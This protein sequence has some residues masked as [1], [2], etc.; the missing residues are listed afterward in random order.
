MSSLV[1]IE[2][3]HLK[4]CPY[5]FRFYTINGDF[6]K[7][8]HFSGNMIYTYGNWWFDSEQT[9]LVNPE[10]YTKAVVETIKDMMPHIY[11]IEKKSDFILALEHNAI[12]HIRIN[13]D[14]QPW[15]E[16]YTLEVE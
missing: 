2:A 4:W 14:P 7:Y 1:E 10:E 16:E 12:G 8:G 11:R 3:R 13:A 6:T 15:L 5:G 9:V